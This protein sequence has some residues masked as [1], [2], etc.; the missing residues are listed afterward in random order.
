MSHARLL[1]ATIAAVLLLA[2]PALA[3]PAVGTPVAK[4]ADT[5]AGAHS[6]FTV[7]FD[8]TGLGAVGTGGDDLKSLV[9]DLPAGLAGNP[10][11][12][13]ATCSKD[14]LT[15]DSCPPATKVGTT[16]T[17]ATVLLEGASQDIN[18][19]IYNE[20]PGPGEAARLG[21]VLRPAGG[22]LPKVVLESPVHVRG[23]DGGLTSTVD[24]IPN[25]ASG[26]DLRIDH[27]A[28]T[29]LG[30]LASG[31]AFMSN[32]TSC[33]AANTTITIGTYG[34]KTAS[35]NAG[36]TPTACDALPFAPQIT[37]SLGPARDDLRVGGHP[38]LTTIV[39]QQ[40]GEANS[41]SVTVTLPIGIGSNFG[42]L[43]N[44]CPLATYQAGACPAASVVGTGKAV[45]PFL[46]QPLTGNVTL[47]IDPAVTLPQ[48][49]IALRGAFP[50]DL[51]ANIA[52]GPNGRLVNTID[53]IF[54]VPISS[55]RLDIAGGP[56][57]PLSAIRDLCVAGTTSLDAAFVA[58]SGK[59]A[60]ATTTAG[61]VGCAA[62]RSPQLHARIGKLAGGRPNLRLKA[63]DADRSLDFFRLRLPRGLTFTKRAA[64]L[65]KVKLVGAGA[66]AVKLRGGALEISITNGGS[67]TADVLVG[68]GAIRVSKKLKHAKHPKLKLRVQSRLAGEKLTA[69]SVALPV[70]A[71]V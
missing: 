28:L 38:A 51:T 9:L 64:A 23:T 68:R 41:K 6:D 5:A 11:A 14:Q 43:S 71:K 22:L 59:Q 4:P 30:K 63:A 29:L 21:I 57:S 24:N 69:S 35:A 50:V 53:G 58:H 56:N 25:T 45:S 54:D 36:F 1:S 12:T 48:L 62:I 40:P 34:G 39:T 61:T 26:M 52:F 33:A 20:T 60:T 2:A 65:T 31:K 16:V 47:V 10:L 13:G 19:D 66:S 3:D 7:S 37:A 8:V 49:R 46:A 15:A 44:A 67:P 70:R 18:G 17:T 42:A 55:F 32:P 27:M